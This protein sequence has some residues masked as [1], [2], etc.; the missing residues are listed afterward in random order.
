MKKVP[1]QGTFF[2]L[3]AVQEEDRD[4]RQEDVPARKLRSFF[5]QFAQR[6]L[7][8]H[9]VALLA[10]ELFVNLREV[11]NALHVGL[12]VAGVDFQRD[13]G[14][15]VGFLD[16]V[17]LLV[18]V[19][20]VVQP[21]HDVAQD[22][23]RRGQASR[24]LAEHELPVVA[25]A[26]D[27]HAVVF[28]VNAVDVLV[29][30][31]ELGHDEHREVLVADL[32]DLRHEF[33]LHPLLAGVADVRVVDRGDAVGEDSFRSHVGSEGVDRDD[34][35]LEERV[36]SFD[37]ERGVALG[38]SQSLS[39]RQRVGI[40]FGV[41]EH[42]REDVVRRTVQNALDLEQQVVVVVL[43]EIADHG[44]RAARRGVVQQCHIV[45][46]LQVDQLRQVAGEHGLVARNDGDAFLEG[47]LDDFVGGRRI[48][49]HLH[50]QVDLRIGED[51]FRIG[52]EIGRV[53]AAG[54]VRP[55]ADLDDFR[56]GV[57]G[58]AEYLEDALSDY[59]EAEKADFDLIHGLDG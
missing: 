54:F 6:N 52:R 15:V 49:D 5:E 14:R 11:Q 37:V 45:F 46:L 48:V 57:A 27:H 56:M 19:A 55:H 8:D 33:D 16:V 43:L 36:V 26:A 21:R 23:R 58:F 29:G 50:D 13:V 2:C 30:R 32:D 22:R 31:H 9:V 59:A 1:C 51:H 34:D 28:V 47:R 18:L 3:I 38:K 41:V 53:D 35:Q 12:L 40:R 10:D 17:H 25:F 7:A 44:D 4:V 20:V 24:A 39:L 42:A